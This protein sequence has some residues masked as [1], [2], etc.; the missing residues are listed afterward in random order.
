MKRQQAEIQ[1][2]MERQQAENQLQIKKLQRQQN[3]AGKQAEL[4]AL[5][6]EDME[7]FMHQN[8][9]VQIQNAVP[10]AIIQ[11]AMQMTPIHRQQP[12]THYSSNENNRGTSDTEWNHQPD[13]YNNQ[14]LQQDGNRRIE[15]TPLL[16][17]PPLLTRENHPGE[18]RSM[19]KRL[20]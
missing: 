17:L 19:H 10:Q 6:E 4:Q 9:P 1:L 13:D 15:T 18:F 7:N 5:E 14:D 12:Q 11:D 16:S 8:P 2:Q 20:I 3:M